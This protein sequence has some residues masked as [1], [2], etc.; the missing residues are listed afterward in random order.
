MSCHCQDQRGGGG[1]GGRDYR[2]G[3]NG[4]ER[5]HQDYRGRDQSERR[6]Y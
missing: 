2:D 5:H 1:Y 3:A 4:R 6:N